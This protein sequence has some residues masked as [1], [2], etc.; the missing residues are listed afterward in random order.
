[1]CAPSRVAL[2][3]I[4]GVALC[5]SQ[6]PKEGLPCVQSGSAKVQVANRDATI[7]GLTIGHASM[8]DV[9]TQLGV[10]EK[11]RVSNEEESDLAECYISPND[12]TVLTFYTGAMGGWKD[13][14]R[15]SLRARDA[16]FSN[17]GK[18]A[19]SMLVS[20]K[21]STKGGLQLGLSEQDVEAI[22]GSP[23]SRGRSYARFE[24]TCRRK[25]TEDE[26]KGF[27]TANNWD[28][29]SDPYFDRTSWVDVRFNSVGA[30]RIEVGM[31]ESY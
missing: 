5:R 31:I 17:S 16:K 12:G 26:I 3:L 9:Q 15:F 13:I 10:A 29:R 1:M 14:T 24:Y 28:V 25:M 11:T 20:R 6:N 30:S 18:C 23:T 7:L 22:E 4:L 21:L 2:L 19:R 27:K 8:N